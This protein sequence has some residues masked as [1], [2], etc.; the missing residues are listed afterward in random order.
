MSSQSC[1]FRIP[2]VWLVSQAG[3][4][5]KHV[6]SQLNIKQ[7]PSHGPPQKADPASDNLY[8]VSTY[9]IDRFSRFWQR[10]TSCKHEAKLWASSSL[11]MLPR[12]EDWR[13]PFLC[14]GSSGLRLIHFKHVRL[15]GKC[16]KVVAH[17]LASWSNKQL[18]CWP[19]FCHLFIIILLLI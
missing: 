9:S 4:Q 5:P 8:S 13:M 18:V 7:P 2:K 16:V 15:Y 12:A 14:C 10:M 17:Q 1:S 11:H 3:P 19:T 6:F